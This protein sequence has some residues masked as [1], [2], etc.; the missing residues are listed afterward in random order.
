MAL[1]PLPGWPLS[2]MIANLS[3]P[4]LFGRRRSCAGDGTL[5][6]LVPLRSGL[7]GWAL[8]QGL[9]AVKPMNVMA[10]GA[11]QEPRGSWFPSVL[12]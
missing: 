11:Y 3:D 8:G 9:R 7:F 1:W 6:M 5:A 10:L 12:Y 4:G 2:P